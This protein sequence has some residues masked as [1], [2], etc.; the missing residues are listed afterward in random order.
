MNTYAV[1]KSGNKQ[2]RVQVG[3]LLEVEKLKSPAQTVI[4]DQVLLYVDGDKVQVGDPILS[5]VKVTGKVVE[6]AVKGEKI[7]VFRYKAKSRYRK[8]RGHRQTH[9][10]VK[11]EQVGKDTPVK[12][13]PT[14]QTSPKKKAPSSKKDTPQKKAAPAKKS[15]K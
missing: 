13:S 7:R 14:K 6:A 3:D 1:I 5:A 15:S 4:F 9:T 12:K 10:L 2:Y 11:I 8:T